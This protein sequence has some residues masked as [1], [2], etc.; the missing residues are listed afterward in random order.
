MFGTTGPEIGLACYVA[1]HCPYQLRTS[2]RVTLLLLSPYAAPRYVQRPYP[3]ESYRV[4]YFYA[5]TVL[6]SDQRDM[7]AILSSRR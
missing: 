3:K 5:I 6:R 7:V 1:S 4:L 2:T